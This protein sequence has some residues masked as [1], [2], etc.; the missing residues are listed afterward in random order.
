MYGSSQKCLDLSIK[1]VHHF[2]S[3]NYV[4][5]SFLF[6]FCLKAFPNFSKHN[7]TYTYLTKCYKMMGSEELKDKYE[8]I[9][10]T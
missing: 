9:F 6:Q 8:K 2:R 3:G 7:L 5:G 1:A 10:S 4:E